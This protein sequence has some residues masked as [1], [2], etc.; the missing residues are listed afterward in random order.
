DEKTRRSTGWIENDV[1][2]AGF[3]DINDELNDMP[4]GS[5][6]TH[7][8]GRTH[9]GKNVL[10]H[11]TYNVRVTILYLDFSKLANHRIQRGEISPCRSLT[12]WIE[13]WKIKPLIRISN[14][15]VDGALIVCCECGIELPGKGG[16]E[17]E[18]KNGEIFDTLH[19]IG[20]TT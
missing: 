15:P 5:K 9:S 10:E 11:V 1:S 20:N 13:T 6:L 19:R 12:A 3:N 17:D 4:R 16:S 2:R 14:Y 7:V 18:Q 8:A